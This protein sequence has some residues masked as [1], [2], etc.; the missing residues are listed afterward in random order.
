MKRLADLGMAR[1]RLREC[2]ER[3]HD[4]VAL[5]STT[6]SLGLARMRLHK[7]SAL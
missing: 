7:R 5:S 3:S 2:A 1:E 6:T 4:R